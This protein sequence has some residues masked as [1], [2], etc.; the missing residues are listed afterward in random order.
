MGIV[1]IDNYKCL[2]LRKHR[3]QYERLMSHILALSLADN[4][5]RLELKRLSIEIP[6][7]NTAIHVILRVCALSSAHPSASATLAKADELVF[8]YSGAAAPWT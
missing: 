6:R 2:A 1:K 8:T 3:W 7:T 5:V 4:R